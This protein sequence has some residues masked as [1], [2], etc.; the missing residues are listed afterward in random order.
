MQTSKFEPFGPF[1]MP[2]DG[3]AIDS[4]REKEKRFWELVETECDGLPDAVGCY[5]FAIRAGKGVRPW[6]VGMT[7]KASFRKECWQPHKLLQ[8]VGALQKRKKGTPVLYLLAKQTPSGRL[9][10]P[11]K[12]RLGA[13]HALEQLL[14]NTCILRNSKL[15]NKKTTK[16]FR[17]IEVPGYMN[18][19]PGARTRHARRL[20]NVLGVAKN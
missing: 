13:V 7:E 10:K 5:I 8:Y 18:E 3:V 11:S 2:V 4:S 15:L 19:S 12:R 6:Y 20:A 16:H 17:G 9:T 14:I 1:K